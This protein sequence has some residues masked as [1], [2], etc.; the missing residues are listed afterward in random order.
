[1][2]NRRLLREMSARD[3]EALRATPLRYLPKTRGGGPFNGGISHGR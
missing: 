2:D 3:E 1:V